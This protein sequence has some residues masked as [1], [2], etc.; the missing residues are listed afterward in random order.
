MPELAADE[1]DYRNVI[2]DDEDALEAIAAAI[3]GTHYEH[4]LLRRV[5]EERRMYGVGECAQYMYPDGVVRWHHDQRC[6]EAVDEVLTVY[7]DVRLGSGL[8]SRTPGRVAG[9]RTMADY[10]YAL[11]G[12]YF[13][14]KQR[15]CEGMTLRVTGV[16]ACHGTKAVVLSWGRSGWWTPGDSRRLCE[17][18]QARVFTWLC[19][20]TYHLQGLPWEV[21]YM[22]LE[23]VANTDTCG[24]EH[25]MDTHGAKCRFEPSLANGTYPPYTEIAEGTAITARMSLDGQV[26]RCVARN[27]GHWGP[28][29]Y[30]GLAAAQ[31]DQLYAEEAADLYAG[32][33][34]RRIVQLDEQIPVLQEHR[35]PPIAYANRRMI[36]V[37]AA[38]EA[39][40]TYYGFFYTAED[41]EE[42]NAFEGIEPSELVD[43]KEA[44]AVVVATETRKA[45][46]RAQK[47]RV[48]QQ[49]K[50]QSSVRRPKQK[51]R[52][53]R[54]GQSRRGGKGGGGQRY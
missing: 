32:I 39:G 19:V 49:R 28:N 20:A 11:R 13:D 44:R 35:G 42:D 3:Y 48:S 37:T 50:K 34:E 17:V 9:P 12:T 21:V 27:G 24:I 29:V 22:I 14:F 45:T 47:S 25:V 54:R 5:D 1:V 4:P 7:K 46:R 15:L 30:P 6:D 38:A 18:T 10:V 51:Y 40:H 36:Q 26:A 53:H 23:W 8:Y 31:V 43:E 52:P 2:Y 16:G 41:D 33:D